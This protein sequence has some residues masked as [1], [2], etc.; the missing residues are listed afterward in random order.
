MC[1]LTKPIIPQ[2]PLRL[3]EPDSLS[4]GQ[5]MFSF[6]VLCVMAQLSPHFEFKYGSKNGKNGKNIGVKLTMYGHTVLINPISPDAYV[7]RIEACRRALKKLKKYNPEWLLPPLPMDGP[8]SPAWNW[9]QLVR[10][11]FCFDIAPGLEQI[12]D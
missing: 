11:K 3:T 9:I 12:A 8:T 6:G 10:G 7:A 2:N 5:V 1:G 4:G